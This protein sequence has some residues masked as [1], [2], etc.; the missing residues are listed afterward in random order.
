MD[1][2]VVVSKKAQ[3][4]IENT[5]DYYQEINDKLAYEFYLSL[6]KT[7]NKLGL[8]PYY[9]VKH[10]NYRATPIEKFSFLLFFTINEKTKI[11]KILSCFHTSRNPKKYPK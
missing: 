4:E 7:Y 1:F 6:Q 11:I 9:Q 8:N 5:I 3:R 2:K 10:K